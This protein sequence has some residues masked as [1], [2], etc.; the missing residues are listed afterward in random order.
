VRLH[1]DSLK[2]TDIPDSKL[3]IGAEAEIHLVDYL[4][5][6]VIKKIRIR[7]QY[8]NLNLDNMLRKKRTIY[9]ARILNNA[10]INGIKVPAVLNVDLEEFSITMEKIEGIPLKIAVYQDFDIKLFEKVG[11]EIAKLHS[12]DIIHGDITT[13]NLLITKNKEIVI[14]DFGLSKFSNSIEDK[15]VDL[16][17]L[18][19]TLE[20]SHAE[21]YEKMW[22]LFFNS[23]KKHIVAHV[24]EIE[25]RL[26]VI[27]Y[28]AR[29][30][31]HDAYG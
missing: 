14:I 4:D 27:E 17:V 30:K 2:I 6:E 26:E 28:R 13:S 7:K 24:S 31:S 23:Y 16:M 11:E 3:S 12:I 18:K 20:S 22:N 9:E 15:S 1:S 21:Y 8:R 5:Y 19:R 10:L 25:K 29:Y